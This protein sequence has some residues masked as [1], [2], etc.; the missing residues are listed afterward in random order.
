MSATAETTAAVLVVYRPT[1]AVQ[2]LVDRLVESVG[3]VIVVDN[4]EAALPGLAVAVRSLGADYEHGGNVGGLAGAYN[5]ALR[6]LRQDRPPRQVVFLDQDSDPSSLRA[7]L[8]DAQTLRLLADADTAAV[9]AA[10]R[11]RATGLRGRY[12]ELR[13][14]SLRYQ[15]R[16]FGGPREVAFVVNSMSVWRW[17]ALQRIGPFDEELAI[18]HVDTEYCLRARRLGLRLFVHGDHEY[19]HAIG[20]RRRYRLF[21][22][23]LQAGGHA[24]QRRY[25]IGRNTTTL[26][27]RWAWREP[28]FAF[29][30][31][32]RLAYEAV[33]IVIAE[34]AAAAKLSALLRGTLRGAIGLRPR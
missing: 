15:P 34:D 16:E 6:L 19:L 33:G 20:Q 7:L 31:L 22:R 25:L 4:T 29:L 21:G 13:R 17:E 5:R 8:A 1:A 26:I 2:G 24:P 14:W 28:A 30:C 32:T 10:Y 3:R 27:R 11:D 18:D 23:D 9:A 12:I